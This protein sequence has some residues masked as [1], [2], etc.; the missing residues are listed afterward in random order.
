MIARKNENLKKMVKSL[1][2]EKDELTRGGDLLANRNGKLKKENEL[3]HQNLMNEKKASKNFVGGT[4]MLNNMLFLQQS[5][6]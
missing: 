6:S 5:P 2:K 1:Q 4:S 3:I